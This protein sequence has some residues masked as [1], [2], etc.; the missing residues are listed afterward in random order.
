MLAVVYYISIF[1][2]S[3]SGVFD[4]LHFGEHS[5][6]ATT[7]PHHRR[8]HDLS[9]SPHHTHALHRANA[10]GCDDHTISLWLPLRVE[11]AR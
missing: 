8:S 3:G 4:V 10:L 9:T 6:E 2:F 11:C 5:D 7:S 1:H